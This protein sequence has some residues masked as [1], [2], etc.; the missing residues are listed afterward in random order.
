MKDLA[1]HILDIVQNSVRAQARHIG[2]GIEEDRTT[3]LLTIRIEDDGYGMDAATLK[4]IRDPFFTSRQIRHVGLGIPLLQQNAERTGGK[5]AIHS[6]QGEGTQVTATFSHSH[7]DRPPLGDIA[8]TVSL[9]MAVNPDIEFTFTHHSEQGHFRINS[10]EV[11]NILD[12]FSLN[13]PD[14]L[15]HL[16]E[17]IDENEKE[18]K[19]E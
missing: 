11:K 16:R 1:S 8:G 9:L 13:D 14:I 6:V 7:L 3:D 19:E 18:I 2:I 15:C 12:G 4:R 10:R 17:L 5:L